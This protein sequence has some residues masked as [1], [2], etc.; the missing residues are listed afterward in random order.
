MI[1]QNHLVFS[2]KNNSGIKWREL[3]GLKNDSNIIDKL[4][5]I[6]GRVSGGEMHNGTENEE[7]LIFSINLPLLIYLQKVTLLIVLLLLIYDYRLC[8]I[9]NLNV[10]IE[11]AK[12]GKGTSST[13]LILS[14]NG[15]IKTIL[16]EGEQKA[17]FINFKP[18]FDIFFLIAYRFV[19]LKL[20]E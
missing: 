13:K 2:N 3:K 20:F 5:T 9:Y 14:K 12:G 15:D 17:V 8:L 6:H 16:S 1:K 4:K 19:F 7:Q 18:F 10:N 11:N